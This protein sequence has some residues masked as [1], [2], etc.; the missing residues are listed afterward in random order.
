M[1]KK[2]VTNHFPLLY[3]LSIPLLHTIYDYLNKNHTEATN[4]M[5]TIDK[6]I[7][8]IPE[9]IIPYIGWYFF[10][11]FYLIYFYQKDRKIYYE[12]LIAT[13]VGMVVCYLFY[14]FFQTT[15]PRPVVTGNEFHINLVRFIYSNDQPYNCFPSIHVLTTFIIMYGMY[16]SE[17]HSFFNR[18]FV[19]VFGLLI[20][21]STVFVKQH[22][23]LDG[24]A[25]IILVISSFA[26]ISRLELA[27]LLIMKEK[28][29][30]PA[31][32]YKQHS[33]H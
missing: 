5:T 25:S 10:M 23:I 11:F 15:F 26:I 8:F 14:F 22:S 9:F 3:L 7:P 1:F 29:L 30:K 17:I 16:R 18:Y 33:H 24:I 28:V 27:S 21:L 13:N 32:Y 6:Q 4:I 12:S 20:I 19:Y 2:L 31:L